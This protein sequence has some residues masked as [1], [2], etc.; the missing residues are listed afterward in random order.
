[1][2]GMVVAALLELGAL[3]LA[4]TPLGAHVALP[5]FAAAYAWE[6][7]AV[8]WRYAAPLL[9]AWAL[10]VPRWLGGGMEILPHAL[11]GLLA[12][13]AVRFLPGGA[14]SSETHDDEP[15]DEA[16][17]GTLGLRD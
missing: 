14:P 1:V 7:R 17:S 2:Q 9:L 10:V 12:W 4:P 8:F 16:P 13:I 6:E 5:L 15:A 3:Y 11:A